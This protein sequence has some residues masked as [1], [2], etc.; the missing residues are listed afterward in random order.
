MARESARSKAALRHKVW[1]SQG[2]CACASARACARL[3]SGVR[4]AKSKSHVTR[5][6]LD[7]RGNQQVRQQRRV[8]MS[9]TDEYIR[10]REEEI[11]PT[12]HTDD[13][14]PVYREKN[15]FS[16]AMWT[17]NPSVPF[18]RMTSCA[19][20]SHSRQIRYEAKKD[21]ERDS[22]KARAHGCERLDPA[23]GNRSHRLLLRHL[24]CAD[25]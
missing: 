10:T 4:P 24:T 8:P 14:V 12:T 15:P 7:G 23:R 5:G 18:D 2:T 25:S 17:I 21:E 9:G 13:C 19:H 1:P 20:A 16:F 22:P 11:N 3:T 6:S